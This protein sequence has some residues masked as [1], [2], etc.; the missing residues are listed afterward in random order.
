MSNLKNKDISVW[1]TFLWDVFICSLGAYGG[2]EAHYGVFTERMILKK[3]YISEEELGEYIALTSIIPGPSSTQTIV[4]IGYKMGGPVLALLTMIV[5]AL[6]IV[7]LM[8]VLSFLYQFL[9]EHQISTDVLRYIGPMAVGFIGVAAYKIGRKVVKGKVNVVLYLFALIITFFFRTV[10]IFPLLL[11]GGGL[12]SVIQSQEKDLWNK[13]KIKP[14]FLYLGLF[15]LIAISAFVMAMIW[16]NQ[17]LWL[18]ER[19]YRYGYLII[20]GGQVVVPYMYTDLVEVHSFM[21]SQEFLTGF[22][23]VQG[24][25]GPM[26]SFSAYAGGMAARGTS[27]LTQASGGLLSAIGIFLPGLLLINFILPVWEQIKGIKGIRVA[28]KGVTVIAAGLITSA[29][30]VLMRDSGLSIA[31]FIVLILTMGLLLSKKVPAPIIVILVI[32]AG[33]I[34]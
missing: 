22:G 18:F 9:V 28:L 29:G 10:W 2:P 13:V 27:L 11:F 20:G 6:P 23:L 30:L 7:V 14:P 12:V 34:I 25:P 24:L 8:T 15:L 5:W 31:N 33:I 19:F 4:A 17:L 32:V 21:T 3:N 26:F 16:D 1:K